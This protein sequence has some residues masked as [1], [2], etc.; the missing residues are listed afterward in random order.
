MLRVG[1]AAC[2]EDGAARV[3]IPT[4]LRQAVVRA[5]EEASRWVV[6]RLEQ[7]VAGARRGGGAPV[8]CQQQHS[9]AGDNSLMLPRWIVTRFRMYLAHLFPVFCAFSTSRRGG[10]NEPQ[11]GTQGQETAGKTRGDRLL[12]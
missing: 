12:P 11:A 7:A 8:A 9:A 1:P 3:P 6:R 2:V 10:S 5:E 4:G